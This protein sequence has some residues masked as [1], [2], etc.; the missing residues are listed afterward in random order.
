MELALQNA[1]ERGLAKFHAS[2]DRDRYRD[3]LSILSETGNHNE[4]LRSEAMRLFTLS[5][6][7]DLSN[8]TE[9]YNL[10]QRISSLAHQ[11]THEEV[12]A[13]P[14]LSSF[15]EALMAE[16]LPV[17]PDGGLS[18][19]WFKS[20]TMSKYIASCKAFTPMCSSTC[21]SQARLGKS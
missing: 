21:S 19:G 12:D 11:Q 17:S 16:L 7:P 1:A 8:L 5:D 10:S 3:I 2:E 9:K 4:E 6:T 14:Y 20:S 15:F 18:M 13:T